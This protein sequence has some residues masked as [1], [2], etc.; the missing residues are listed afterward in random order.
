[1]FFSSLAIVSVLIATFSYLSCNRVNVV[2]TTGKKLI[3]ISIF[4]TWAVKQRLCSGIAWLENGC[5]MFHDHSTALA[6]GLWSHT[7]MVAWRA[8]AQ[9]CRA[10]FSTLQFSTGN[11]DV[12]TLIGSGV[13]WQAITLFFCFFFF[14]S[15]LS[16]L[17]S[18]NSI[19][20]KTSW[21]Q[22]K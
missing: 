15:S 16:P 21:F 18:M 22:F 13:M 9:T 6:L 17:S 20:V 10:I 11:G 1:M 8:M 14:Y 12:H 5:Y 2:K 4:M 3:I 7:N 19:I